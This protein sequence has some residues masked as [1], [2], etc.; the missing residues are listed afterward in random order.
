MAKLLGALAPVLVRPM[1]PLPSWSSIPLGLD[2]N[3]QRNAAYAGGGQVNLPADY[4]LKQPLHTAISLPTIRT[5]QPPLKLRRVSSEAV[6]LG[7]EGALR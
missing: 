7:T 2:P 1:T 5:S 3:G 4:S 6:D